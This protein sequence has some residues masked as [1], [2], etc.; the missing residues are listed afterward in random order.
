M[1]AQNIEHARA[2][3]WGEHCVGGFETGAVSGQVTGLVKAEQSVEKWR[4]NSL[5]ARWAWWI[6]LKTFL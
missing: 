5:G 1:E 2:G 4:I 6:Y 3:A